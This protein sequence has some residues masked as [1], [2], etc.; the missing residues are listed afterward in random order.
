MSLR[1]IGA[2][3][4]R[5]GTTSLK[6]ALERLLGAPC[7]HMREV[8]AH[9][10]HLAMWHAAALGRMPEWRDVFEGY[11]AAIDWPAAAFWRELSEYYPD[12]LIV[13]SLRAP[14]AWWR[15]ASETIFPAMARASNDEWR[16][17]IKTVLDA[18]FTPHVTDRRAS[19][20]AYE[21]HLVDV[22]KHAPP[23]RLLQWEPSDGWAP[24]CDALGVPVPA[25]PFP[26]ANN[27][28]EFLARP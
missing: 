26:H 16:A 24:L 6:L 28:Q 14:E 20:A 22:C 27:R 2:G 1:V 25:E 18:R 9:P 13:L 4:G 19:L 7:Y 5:T 12:A 17:M 15:S 3:V 11:C 23:Q 21:R 8:F 10:A